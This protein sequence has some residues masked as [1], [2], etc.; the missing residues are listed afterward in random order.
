MKSLKRRFDQN[1]K[2]NPFWSSY[3]CFAI[4]IRNQKFIKKTINYWFKRLVE[5]VD[6]QKAEKTTIVNYLYNLSNNI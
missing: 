1:T 3:T 2:R 5:G 4:A 6:Y